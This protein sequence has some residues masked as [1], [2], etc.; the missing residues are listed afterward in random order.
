MAQYVHLANVFEL[1]IHAQYMS[2][3]RVSEDDSKVTL[4]QAK[5]VVSLILNADDTEESH[6]RYIDIYIDMCEEAGVELQ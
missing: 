3:E 5:D 6:E 1:Y 2:E 4:D